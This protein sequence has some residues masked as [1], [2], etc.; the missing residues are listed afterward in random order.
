MKYSIIYADLPWQ[1]KKSKGK[2]V[3]EKPLSHDEF[4]GYLQSAH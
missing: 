1:Y 4:K 2:G 3:A